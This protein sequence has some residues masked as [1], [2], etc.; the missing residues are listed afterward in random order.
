MTTERKTYPMKT[1]LYLVDRSVQYG[2]P[3]PKVAE[4]YSNAKDQARCSAAAMYQEGTPEW[5]H[6]YFSTL[7]SIFMRKLEKYSSKMSQESRREI[8]DVV[9]MH[10]VYNVERLAG[11]R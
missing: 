8:R 9:K 1:A 11:T 10:Y 4:L 2:I 7:Y 5:K 3:V 6:A